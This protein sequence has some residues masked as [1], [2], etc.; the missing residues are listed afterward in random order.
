M[1]SIKLQKKK[2]K[3]KFDIRDY[4]AKKE[5]NWEHFLDSLFSF[6]NSS[7]TPSNLTN[8][9]YRHD[10]DYVRV[11]RKNKKKQAKRLKS[12]KNKLNN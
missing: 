1:Y 12:K 3:K 5:S 8:K 2:V 6:L 11:H 9:T 4:Q 7:E 10:Y